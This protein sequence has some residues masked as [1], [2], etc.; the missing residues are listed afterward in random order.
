MD[1]IKNCLKAALLAAISIV[2]IFLIC[3]KIGSVDPVL[4]IAITALITSYHAR[5]ENNE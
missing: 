1:E 3:N 4:C 2:V 5:F